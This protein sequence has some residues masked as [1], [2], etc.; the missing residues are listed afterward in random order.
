MNGG[1]QNPLS[2]C[3]NLTS[4]NPSFN[5]LLRISVRFISSS[6]SSSVD[7]IHSTSSSSFVVSYLMNS[8]GLTEKEALSASKKVNF[9]STSNPDTVL[10]CFQ[11][12]GFTKPDISKLINKNPGFLSLNAHKTLKPKL[13]YLN[14]KDISRLEVVKVLSTNPT[15]LGRSLE[16]LIVPLFDSIKNIVG[17]DKYVFAVFRRS[18]GLSDK[19]MLNIQVLRDEGVPQSSIVKFLINGPRT[20]LIS[21]GKFKDIVQEIKGM[22]FDPYKNAFLIAIHALAAMTKSTWET[23][24]NAYRKWGWSEDQIQFAF[25]LNPICMKHSEKKI[26]MIMDYLVNQMGISPLLIARCPNVLNYSL[27][28]R[29]IPRC[30]VYRSLVSKGLVNKDRIRITSLLYMSDKSFLDKFVIKYEEEAPELM[31]DLVAVMDAEDT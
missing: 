10:T 6:S 25:M 16:N 23:K 21:T 5:L 9:K 14:S 29:I 11:G 13:D 2:L 4:L 30:S 27:E 20:L 26:S 3:S 17:T 12:Y 22:G 31:K 18:M 28:K 15:I 24:L 7:H 1:D 19:L 8:C